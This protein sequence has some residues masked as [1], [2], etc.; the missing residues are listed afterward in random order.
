MR[1]LS[2]DEPQVLRDQVTVKSI[3]GAREDLPARPT[4]ARDAQPGT[5][6]L[7]TPN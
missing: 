2:T 5:I 3:G 6:T 1:K 7:P 4:L